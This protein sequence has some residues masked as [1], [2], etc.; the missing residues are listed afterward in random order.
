MEGT[1]KIARYLFNHG[2]E[3]HLQ[4]PLSPG[5]LQRARGRFMGSLMVQPVPVIYK[6]VIKVSKINRMHRNTVWGVRLGARETDLECSRG[7]KPHIWYS[8]P[9]SVVIWERRACDFWP[10]GGKCCGESLRHCLRPDAHPPGSNTMA[11][12]F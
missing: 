8:V 12:P 5:K 3:G 1:T 6:V 4:Y 11:G 9:G 10:L 2:R 7:C